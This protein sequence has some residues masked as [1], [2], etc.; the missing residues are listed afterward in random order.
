MGYLLIAFPRTEILM[1]EDQ[2]I[3]IIL[4]QFGIFHR[5]VAART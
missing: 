3:E 2:V 5:G 4:S 1:T